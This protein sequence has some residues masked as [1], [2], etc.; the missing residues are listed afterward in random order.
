MEWPLK[1]P[2]GHHDDGE[3]GVKPNG[4]SMKTMKKKECSRFYNLE[5]KHQA[6][7]Q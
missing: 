7:K 5:V 4:Q 6:R 2:I 1:K 3:K